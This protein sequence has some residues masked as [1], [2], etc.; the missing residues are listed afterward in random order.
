MIDA[1][2]HEP[3]L[4]C[5]YQNQHPNESV[6][7]HLESGMVALPCTFPDTPI[8]QVAA[9][10]AHLLIL[11]QAGQ[12][13]ACGKCD[14]GA[15]GITHIYRDSKRLFFPH[16]IPVTDAYASGEHGAGEINLKVR[17]EESGESALTPMQLAQN[18]PSIADNFIGPV[19]AVAAGMK[20]S[21]FL[22]AQGE[23]Y[24][25]G[26]NGLNELGNNTFHPAHGLIP[27]RLPLLHT[28]PS[29]RV[30]RRQRSSDELEDAPFESFFRA[31]ALGSSREERIVKVAAGQHHSLALSNRGQVYA[32]GLNQ[33]GQCGV[34]VQRQWN[35]TWISNVLSRKAKA[36]TLADV[37]RL[38]DAARLSPTPLDAVTPYIRASLAN[39]APINTARASQMAEVCVS[40]T[41]L[42]IYEHAHAL[43]TTK[44][45]LGQVIDIMAGFHDSGTTSAQPCASAHAHLSAAPPSFGFPSVHSSYSGVFVFVS[46][47]CSPSDRSR[48]L[49]HVR[50]WPG[51]GSLPSPLHLPPRLSHA[52]CAGECVTSGGHGARGVEKQVQNQAS[53]I[54]IAPC[55][56]DC[57]TSIDEDTQHMKF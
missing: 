3:R 12:V 24:A 8:V 37:R 27:V 38:S 33:Q 49:H 25:C 54:W 21:L 26:N 53:R 35:N 11:T 56:R 2:N 14:T 57:A 28:S 51:A 6:A 29:R 10:W 20:H 32:W 55:D 47:L 41:R 5:F 9:G 16:L 50:R 1:I 36:P 31:S 15:L 39:L 42:P 4:V 44:G 22:N 7:R 40:P 19:I 30:W 17:A 48:L 23:V 52:A 45:E 34:P 18:D 43:G 13:Y 46:L